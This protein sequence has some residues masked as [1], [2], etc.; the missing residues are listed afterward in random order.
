MPTSSKTMILDYTGVTKLSMPEMIHKTSSKH[1]ESLEVLYCYRWTPSTSD[2]Q[3]QGETGGQ[4]SASGKPFSNDL[5]LV[6]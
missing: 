1:L 5:S 2:F 4:E 3:R 6:K